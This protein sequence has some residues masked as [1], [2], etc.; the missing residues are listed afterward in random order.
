MPDSGTGW[1]LLGQCW[2]HTWAPLQLL[3]WLQSLRPQPRTEVI[4]SLIPRGRGDE[5]IPATGTC[6]PWVVVTVFFAK[7]LICYHKGTGTVP[8]AAQ[9]FQGCF[10]SHRLSYK[11]QSHPFNT[12]HAP[13]ASPEQVAAQSR[14]QNLLIL[15][16]TI[17]RTPD[18]LL[19]LI[20][21]A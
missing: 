6:Q 17:P 20:Y 8:F 11:M 10:S 14:S 15:L 9:Q 16:C 18:I 13:T 3:V 5:S 21:P 7:I 12:P 2:A 19:D 4:G 1:V